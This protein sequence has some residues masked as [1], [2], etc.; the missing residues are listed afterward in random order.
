M[1]NVKKY[2]VNGEFLFNLIADLVFIAL[3][4]IFFILVDKIF[5]FIMQQVLFKFSV[6]YFQQYFRIQRFNQLLAE[7]L[8]VFGVLHQRVDL[9]L[10]YGQFFVDKLVVQRLVDKNIKVSWMDV[11]LK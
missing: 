7:N 10:A 11:F 2:F 5:V 8:V 6:I 1:L 9:L 3:Q 4:V